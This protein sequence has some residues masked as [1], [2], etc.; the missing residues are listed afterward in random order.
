[1]PRKGDLVMPAFDTPEPIVATLDLALSDVRI[2]ASDRTDTTVE[3]RPS[4]PGADL[5]VTAA[6]QTRVE[7]AD[8]H[9]LIKA[10]KQRKIGTFG[11]PGSTEVD[12]TLPAGSRLEITAGIANLVGTGTLGD[13]RIKAGVGDLTLDR[14]GQLDLT[15]GVGD[16]AVT[17]AAGRATMT[18][19]GGLLRVGEVRD[20]AV[21]KNANGESRIGTVGGNLKVSN[22]NGDVRAEQAGGDVTATTANGSVRIGSVT[23]GAVSVKTAFGGVEIGIADGTAA[24]LDLHTGFGH[25]RNRLADTG[26][27]ATG[28]QSVEIRARTAYGDILIS[29]ADEGG[30]R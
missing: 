4:D 13:V 30:P 8:G 14:T 6:E 7:Y 25:L 2:S 23:R 18:T 26:G 27:P 20:D 1:M 11:K 22:S 16:V 15:T 9:L 12:I 19:G 5:D 3:V 28:E 21:L 17:A 24:H 29:R 10:P